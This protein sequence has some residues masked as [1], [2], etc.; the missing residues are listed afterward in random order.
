MTFFAN[1]G[2]CSTRDDHIHKAY[3]SN[4]KRQ[5]A[6]LNGDL[7]LFSLHPLSLSFCFSKHSI[8]AK[9]ARRRAGQGSL[10]PSLLFTCISPAFNKSEASPFRPSSNSPIFHRRYTHTTSPSQHTRQNL[11]L[12]NHP[13]P[14]TH[15]KAQ[16][17][18]HPHA[19]RS[20]DQIPLCTQLKTFESQDVLL[21]DCEE[22]APGASRLV[23]F[24]CLDRW[25]PQKARAAANSIQSVMLLYISVI[26]CVRERAIWREGDGET[27]GGGKEGEGDGNG[28]LRYA[29]AY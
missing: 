12:Y 3:I 14:H 22:C 15:S 11:P 24:E 29:G 26:Q 13:L 27:G 23:W 4:Q 19:M 7:P 25:R 9:S 6:T 21:Q 5:A 28:D 10:P 2:L 8:Y 18:L 17:K 20:R 16:A 1:C